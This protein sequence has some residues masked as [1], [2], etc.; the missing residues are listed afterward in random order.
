M[1]NVTDHSLQNLALKAEGNSMF[2]AH[3]T[4]ISTSRPSPILKSQKLKLNCT[5]YMPPMNVILISL[6][7]RTY[8]EIY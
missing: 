5:S 1:K 3:L 7:L 4:L 8:L 6:M 2:N